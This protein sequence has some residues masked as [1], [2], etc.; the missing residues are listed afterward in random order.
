MNMDFVGVGL[1]HLSFFVAAVVLAVY[2]MKKGE[3]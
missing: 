3:L 1:Y 2:Q